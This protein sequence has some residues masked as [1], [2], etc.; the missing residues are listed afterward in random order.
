MLE[1]SSKKIFTALIFKRT[2][3][4]CL[5]GVIHFILFHSSAIIFRQYLVFATTQLIKFKVLDKIQERPITT[6]VIPPLK[7]RKQ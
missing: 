1:V 6:N 4:F 3:K 2:L 7:E 5:Y